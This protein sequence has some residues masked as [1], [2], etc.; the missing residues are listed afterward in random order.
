MPLRIVRDEH[1]LRGAAHAG[2]SG[3]ARPPGAVGGTSASAAA[4]MA[5]ARPATRCLL[6]E[7]HVQPLT[8]CELCCRLNTLMDE[9]ASHFSMRSVAFH[10]SSR[11]S[12][13]RRLRASAAVW[14]EAALQQSPVPQPLPLRA[15]PAVPLVRPN[16]V[17]VRPDQ[18]QHSL[19]HRVGCQAAQ[20][21]SG[22]APPDCQDVVTMFNVWRL[23]DVH[24]G[25]DQ[26]FTPS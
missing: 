7:P 23:V 17:R 21:P 25:P 20:M 1:G 5:T 2:V 6:A 4:A 3:A 13:L 14:A 19:R 11:A 22:A 24:A 8:L 15:L 10:A 12:T 9:R 16:R 18:L 26:S